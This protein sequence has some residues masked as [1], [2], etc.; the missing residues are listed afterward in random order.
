M[1]TKVHSAMYSGNPVL[2]AGPAWESLLFHRGLQRLPPSRLGAGF[3][4]LIMGR[5]IFV[6][7]FLE[8]VLKLLFGIPA[9]L[10]H[11]AHLLGRGRCMRMLV[12]SIV[13]HVLTP[14]LTH[15][16][17]LPPDTDDGKRQ[18]PPPNSA[19]ALVRAVHAGAKCA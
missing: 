19:A 16:C 1:P 2:A 9:A 17:I 5:I 11:C 6:P 4:P 18:L 7:G 13:T 10:S 12:R 14:M 3:S 8:M 15:T